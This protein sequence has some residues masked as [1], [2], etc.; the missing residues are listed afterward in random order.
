MALRTHLRC[1]HRLNSLI[2]TGRI[3]VDDVAQKSLPVSKLIPPDGDSLKGEWALTQSRH[4]GLA[5]GLYTLG[6]CNFTFPREKSHRTH[7]AEIDAKWVI[8]AFRRSF[9][10]RRSRNRSLPDYDQFVL[11]LEFFLRFRAGRCLAFSLDVGVGPALDHVYA[12]LGKLRQDVLDLL[13]LD[14]I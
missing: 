10:A 11:G 1:R 13:G 6:D 8:G 5:A 9:G 2:T 12:H 7:V 3:K 14:I 4:H